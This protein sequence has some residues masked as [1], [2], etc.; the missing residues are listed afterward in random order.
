MATDPDDG[1]NGEIYYSLP[2]RNKYFVV[3]P[4]TG[5]ISLIKKLSSDTERNFSLKILAEDRAS[6][7]FPDQKS[8]KLPS[9]ATVN[10]TVKSVNLN[11]PT[12]I[13][14]EN[15]TISN[16]INLCGVGPSL[17][18]CAL[19]KT[20]DLDNEK[21]GKIK[22]V[23]ILSGDY[24][25]WFVINRASEDFYEIRSLGDVPNGVYHLHIGVEDDGYPSKKSTTRVTVKVTET[26][27]ELKSS[28]IHY[29]FTV[30]ECSARGTIVGF[31]GGTDDEN[32]LRGGDFSWKTK[33]PGP[34]KINPKNGLL[35][36][37]NGLNFSTNSK[38]RLD[39]V[40]TNERCSQTIE[41]Q[42]EI[43]VNDCN[44]H[45]PTFDDVSCSNILIQPQTDIESV[46]CTVKASDLDV[47]LN[48][49][50]SYSLHTDNKNLSKLF[51]IDSF[52]GVLKLSGP[53]T[54]E[55]ANK[56]VTFKIRASDWG[57]PY[58]LE[59]ELSVFARFGSESK[60]ETN[61]KPIVSTPDNRFEPKFDD[62]Q[63]AVYYVNENAS[64]GSIVF[65]IRAADD[66][67]G[68]AGFVRYAI[69]D[70]NDDG[71]WTIE[72]DSGKV[73]PLR[74]LDREKLSKFSLLIEAVDS[75][76]PSKSVRKNI[77]IELTDYNDDKPKFVQQFYVV[78]VSEDAK[79][80]STIVRLKA[81][82]DDEGE[83]ARVS[84]FL[85][86]ES[87][88]FAIETD[89]GALVLK[90]TLDREIRAEYKLTVNA[91][92]HGSP[93]LSSTTLVKIV[94]DDVNDNAPECYLKNQKFQLAEDLPVNSLITCVDSYDPD[95][96]PGGHVAYRLS[97]TRD[98]FNLPKAASKFAIES[99][100]GCIW[101]QGKHVL[102][103]YL[104]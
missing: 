10:I 85:I 44:D 56:E 38:Y 9:F 53:V 69:I 93:S 6:R 62:D 96:G 18:T 78:K 51:W 87:S 89:S 82:D 73:R 74:N 22:K 26:C 34:F 81:T 95:L 43:D 84:Y 49:K 31:V 45:A 66:D 24:D 67:F 27:P 15:E 64:V 19:L 98:P 65:A 36:V 41:F 23:E 21:H 55:Y 33:S 91:I 12:L 97:E 50:I 1:L 25:H 90:Q 52:N 80:G 2:E 58:R 79:I 77:S 102:R 48:G 35:T 60:P 104:R 29:K 11:A 83:N 28:V 37:A 88:I 42:A 8:A 14:V 32:V 5:V 17:R 86:P 72:S 92:D 3:N 4:N 39:V 54:V 46:L 57:V 100:S 71:F 61:V 20:A 30:D 94:V 99:D 76:R 68:A 103:L 7:L 75:G 70:G 16:V 63:S 101:L 59:S 47:G 13:V 40:A